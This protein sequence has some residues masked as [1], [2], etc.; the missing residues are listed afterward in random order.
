MR[1]PDEVAAMLRLRGLGWGVRRIA[2]EFGCSHVTVRRYVAAGGWTGYR[3]P[4]RGKALDGLEDWL[5]ERFRRHRGNA[6]VVRQDLAREKGI[7]VSLRTVERAVA[8]LRQALVAEARVTVRFETP[9]GRQLQIDFGET[10]VSIGG[11]SLRVH[12]FV[13]TLG[14]SRRCFVRAFRHERQSAWF[15]GIEAAFRHFGGVPEEVLLDNARAL[16]EQHDTATREVR[17]NA[18]LHAFARYWAFR[19]RACAP[20]RARTKGK[21]ER[22]V[23]Y[24][25][26]NAIAGHRFA[27][28]AAL[29]AHLQWWMREITDPRV[30]GTTGE[31]PLKRFRRD[32]A[33][34]G[35]ER[36]GRRRRRPRKHPARRP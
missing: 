6:D 36:A 27:S 18:R 3:T 25:K 4:R 30:H 11:E 16:V 35:R 31:P 2:A 28:W 1:E 21:D 5:A 33:A 23:G 20:Y 34:D 13:A 15:D 9:P 26:H 14:Y 22:G 19:P 24:V 10:R 12:L 32:E 8:P 17:F 29:E 7:V